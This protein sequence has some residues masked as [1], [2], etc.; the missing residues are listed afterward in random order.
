[1]NA[2][3]LNFSKLTIFLIIVCIVI[4]ALLLFPMKEGR[5]EIMENVSRWSVPIFITK[6]QTDEKGEATGSILTPDGV[7]STVR[8]VVHDAQGTLDISELNKTYRYEVIFERQK[9]NTILVYVDPGKDIA[10]LR[11]DFG[12]ENRPVNVPFAI[13]GD[14]DTLY[15]GQDVCAIGKPLGKLSLTCGVVSQPAQDTPSQLSKVPLIQVDAAINPGNSGGALI[16]PTNGDFMGMCIGM[17]PTRENLGFCIGGNYIKESL[18][19]F[20]P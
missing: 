1:M 5:K 8:H 17:I 7:I 19:Q 4:L 13:I 16:D 15:M 11:L 6:L 14:S 9:Y 3:I 12:Q 2:Q 10:A 18:A 20:L